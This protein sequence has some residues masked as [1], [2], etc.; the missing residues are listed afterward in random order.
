MEYG[1]LI[2]QI[3]KCHV[4]EFATLGDWHR[5]FLNAFSTG[6]HFNLYENQLTSHKSFE[7][8]D[9]QREK[10]LR[11]KPRKENPK[12]E[13]KTCGSIKKNNAYFEGGIS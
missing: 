8:D 9:S 6:S 2:F 4:F 13:N 1:I 10:P 5:G 12:N 7:V 3:N 11:R